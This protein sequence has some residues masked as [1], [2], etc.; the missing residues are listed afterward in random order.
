M[1]P[2]AQEALRRRRPTAGH[3]ASGSKKTS[4]GAGLWPDMPPVAL[5]ALRRRRPSAG[6]AASG[7]QQTSGSG[8]P[9]APPENLSAGARRP[10]PPHPPRIPTAESSAPEELWANGILGGCGGRA[11]PRPSTCV[12]EILGGCGGGRGQRPLPVR[13]HTCGGAPFGRAAA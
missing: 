7:S 10:L 2:V 8:A 12:S 6:H 3:A 4:G 5:E 11:L 9:P 13:G 1:P